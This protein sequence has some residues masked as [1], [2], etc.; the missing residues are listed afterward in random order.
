MPMKSATKRLAGRSYSAFGGPTWSK[1]SDAD[2]KIFETVLAEAAARATA[3]IV[4][5]E[6]KLGAEFAKR[7]KEV[8]KVDRLPFREAVAKLHN[9]P[10][11]TWDKATYDKL[12]A[13][14]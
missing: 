2:K 14:K 13:L 5:V 1:L 3:E 8:V 4:E 10:D 9:G 7:G 11:A 12:Q 6:K